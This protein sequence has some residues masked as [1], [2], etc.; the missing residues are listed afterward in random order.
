MSDCDLLMTGSLMGS[1]V[2]FRIVRGR[3]LK[4]FKSGRPGTFFKRVD[5]K[6]AISK[7]HLSLSY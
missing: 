4:N 1:K 5:H 6:M 7:D 2:S 3:P